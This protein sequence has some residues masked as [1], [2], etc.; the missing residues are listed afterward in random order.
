MVVVVIKALSDSSELAP[1][2][3]RVMGAEC[4]LLPDGANGACSL[5]PLTD[6]QLEELDEATQPSCEVVMQ[7]RSCLCLLP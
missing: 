7:K 6:E 3:Q 5:V 4:K 1:Q 2:R